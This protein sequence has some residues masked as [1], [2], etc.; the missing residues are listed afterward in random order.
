[1]RYEKPNTTV[2]EVDFGGLLSGSGPCADDIGSPS[3]RYNYKSIWDYDTE[4]NETINYE[5]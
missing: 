4:D 3:V 2:V 5:I 1:M